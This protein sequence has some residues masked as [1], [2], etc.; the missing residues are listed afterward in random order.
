MG[1]DV[2]P[3]REFITHGRNGLLTPALDPQALA[4]TVLG[5]LED[6]KL[7]RRYAPARAATP[8]VTSTCTPASPA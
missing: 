1:A 8:S 5:V 6:D 4:G 7:N 2:Q 3:V